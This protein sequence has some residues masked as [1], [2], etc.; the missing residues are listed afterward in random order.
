MKKV[1]R[2]L[3]VMLVVALL[4]TMFGCTA[5][6][7]FIGAQSTESRKY[8]VSSCASSVKNALESFYWGEYTR[9]TTVY[10]LVEA[11]Q[12][13]FSDAT[14]EYGTTYSK[15]NGD[16]PCI[17]L[18][19]T[20]APTDATMLNYYDGSNDARRMIIYVCTQYY[21]MKISCEFSGEY[22]GTF[23]M[24]KQPTAY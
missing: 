2:L 7:G 12:S 6:A 14:I 10:Q 1:T 24:D 23:T 17:V 11:L 13:D 16:D 22:G 18:S 5:V 4:S 3:I 15:P 20:I 9:S 21:Y 19:S 8:A